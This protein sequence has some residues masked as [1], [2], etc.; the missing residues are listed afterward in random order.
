MGV[1]EALLRAQIATASQ[2]DE[3]L[4]RQQLYGA[5]IVT[6]LLELVDLDEAAI[7][8]AL[9]EAYG[10]PMA[11]VGELPYAAAA[12]I[13]L[14][15]K[16]VATELNLYP[17]R[18]E[19]GVLTVI[20]SAP[21]LE[22]TAL[23]LAFSLKVQLRA[24]FA[25][26]PRIKQAIARDY[27]FALDR[28]GLKA[29]AKLDGSLH[30]VKSDGP[31]PLPAPRGVS[32]FP[33]P[34]SIMP[35]GF[36]HDWSDAVTPDSSR[37]QVETARQP[38]VR[39]LDPSDLGDAPE[40]SRSIFD[41]PPSSGRTPSGGAGP[42]S[43]PADSRRGQSD[44]SARGH[45]RR[46]PYTLVDAKEDLSRVS[47]PD[48]VLDVFFDYAAQYFD[49]AVAL[50]LHGDGA[51]ARE[52][53][54]RGQSLEGLPERLPLSDHP[55]LRRVLESK[56]LQL[57]DLGQEDPALA[58]VLMRETGHASLLLPVAVRSRVVVLLYGGFDAE[59][60]T[61][62]QVGDLL[63]FCPLVA[64]A[65]ER[66]ILARKGRGSA[67][68]VAGPQRPRFVAPTAEERAKALAQVLSAGGR[69]K[70]HE[71]PSN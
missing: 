47:N 58:R 65:F 53:R 5:D 19:E 52:A 13:E 33:R 38:V 56:T 54:G 64:Q 43:G 32:Q 40:T 8:R 2:I 11:P 9:A 46:G 1:R 50:A 24:L 4:A 12:A 61:L 14:L 51:Q 69:R 37:V 27:A 21:I 23:D 68:V 25:I 35:F 57:T 45:R 3:A 42:A 55:A 31:P 20:A 36:P 30:Y 39:G 26:S 59:P 6:N 70:G 28:R 41:L 10:M 18:L 66:A 71:P 22:R 67:S 16:E 34:R 63:A 62:D 29:L 15:P 49:Y 60:V 48:E 44:P 7:Q 17:F